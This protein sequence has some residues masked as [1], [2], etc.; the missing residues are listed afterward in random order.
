VAGVVAFYLGT[1][2]PAPPPE[3]PNVTLARQEYNWARTALDED[4]FQDAIDRLERA[5]RLSPG[6]DSEGLLTQA[7]TE[8]AAVDC[9]KRAQGLV[10]QQRFEDARAEIM[11]CPEASEKRN[12]DRQRLQELLDAQQMQ[13]LETAAQR[14][15]NENDFTVFKQI[16]EAMPVGRREPWEARGKERM[17]L[18]AAQKAAEEKR[19]R[20]LAEAREAQEKAQRMETA[21][22][23][24]ARKLNEQ[25]YERATLECDRVIEQYGKDPDVRERAIKVKRLIPRFRRQWEEGLRR[26]QEDPDGGYE[27]LRSAYDLYSEIG[28]PG[29]LD[30]EIVGYLNF[31]AEAKAQT[32]MER[33]DFGTAALAYRGILERTPDDGKARQGLE[34]LANKAEDLFKLAYILRD[35]DPRKSVELY[36]T[37]LE[38][39]P[40]GSTLYQK[41]T[42]QLKLSAP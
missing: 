34:R 30:S 10:A 18:V 31:A 35:R 16:V 14:A 2:K 9:F 33:E 38:I 5:E 17:E 24:V 27:A 1:R 40:K 42:E 15:L 21:F 8:L 36:K 25:A 28:L 37:V 12:Q 19:Q 7:R 29:A 11:R 26:V 23:S 3:N 4:R 13:A 22:G 20:E 6:I 32:A 41:S 39:V